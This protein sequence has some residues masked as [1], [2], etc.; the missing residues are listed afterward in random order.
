MS[1]D[2]PEI[3]IGLVG[4]AGCDMDGLETSLARCLKEVGYQ[5]RLIRLTKLLKDCGLVVPSDEYDDPHLDVQIKAR[6]DAGTAFRERYG[7]S[8]MASLAIAGIRSRRVEEQITQYRK[9]KPKDRISDED[10]IQKHG[11]DMISTPLSSVAWIVR[12]LKHPQEV[13]LLRSVYGDAFLL[14]AAHASHRARIAALADKIRKSYSRH[15]ADDADA[16]SYEAL[17]TDLVARDEEEPKAEHGQQVRK[18]FWRGDAYVDLTPL[19]GDVEPLP[20]RKDALQRIINIW[21]RHPYITPTRSEY[22]MFLARGSALRSASM[23]RQVGAAIVS[24]DGSVLATGTNEIPR[25]PGGQYWDGDWPDGRDHARGFDSSDVMKRE[26]IEDF[27]GRL[28][29]MGWKA[30]EEVDDAKRLAEDVLNHPLAQAAE[31]NALTEYQRPVHA[32]MSALMD[33]TRRGVSVDGATLYCT[34][35]PCH[36]CARHIVAAGIRKVVYIEPYPKSLVKTLYSDSAAVEEVDDQRVTF[37]P[38]IG[39]A[40]RRYLAFFDMPPRRKD[41]FGAAL[42]WESMKKAP[43][44]GRD[45]TWSCIHRENQA[46]QIWADTVIKARLRVPEESE[47]HVG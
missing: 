17:A 38:F 7:P 24:P 37:E 47:K 23:G 35:F 30:P 26:A 22:A 28:I 4:A 20:P 21:F 25:F 39:I 44:V 5:P 40:P 29:A 12:S 36:G 31:L 19:P 42:D 13:E 1:I 41:A 18:T 15:R 6:M 33:A 34:T 46:E 43:N 3:V 2:T 27:L 10:L 14:L 9:Y 8:A 16:R 45:E 32:E 11:K